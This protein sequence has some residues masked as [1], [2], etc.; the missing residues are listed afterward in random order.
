MAR[1]GAGPRRIA[2]A[3][4]VVGL[5]ASMIP[6]AG[7]AQTGVEP[8]NDHAGPPWRAWTTETVVSEPD[9]LDPDVDGWEREDIGSQTVVDIGPDDEPQLVFRHTPQDTD[10]P[11]IVHAWRD[12]GEWQFDVVQHGALPDDMAV[13][14]QGRPWVAW[15]DDGQAYV[16][17]RNSTDADWWR[18]HLED[19]NHDLRI[20]IGPN[21]LVHLST[22]DKGADPDPV[23][24]GV[25]DPDQPEDGW[26]W[27]EV[28]GDELG[29]RDLAVGPDGRAHM[30]WVSWTP[31]VRYAVETST[32]WAISTLGFCTTENAVDV[33]PQG[34]VHV[35]CQSRGNPEGVVHAFRDPGDE[36]WTIELASDGGQLVEARGA[37]EVGFSNDIVVDEEG[38]PHIA[39]E[40][41]ASFPNPEDP[42]NPPRPVYAVKANAPCPLPGEARDVVADPPVLRWTPQNP[43]TDWHVQAVD[44]EG[45]QSSRNGV[46]LA[47]DSDGVPS[48]A[49]TFRSRSSS[50]SCHDVVNPCSDVRLA[51]PA[52]AAVGS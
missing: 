40:T 48:F 18:M 50:Q 24:H 27:T 4:L 47:L 17:T 52:V 16:A 21:G 33:G 5:L 19:G 44:H 12:A 3:V 34:T 15:T 39:Y 26:S 1:L 43:C 35:A 7:V 23:K 6:L 28:G 2:L 45:L 22:A 10:V 13:D 31:A 32:G 9:P 11:D 38:V 46:S 49:Y 41:R 8:V 25:F 14:E 20:E 51:Q 36:G 29:W 37:D 30:V 42:R